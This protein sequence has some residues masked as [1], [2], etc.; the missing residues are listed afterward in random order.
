MPATRAKSSVIVRVHE[1]DGYASVE[2]RAFGPDNTQRA[3]A[4]GQMEFDA[5][6]LKFVSI[7]AK[8]RRKKF[9]PTQV[10]P[11]SVLARVSI[12]ERKQGHSKP[13]QAPSAP[14]PV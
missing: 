6:K 9:D 4:N 2:I 13:A 1:S 3:C 12:Q 7:P 10:S 8:D 14:T 5:K 11:A